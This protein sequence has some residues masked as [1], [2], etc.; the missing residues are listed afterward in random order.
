MHEKH[1]Q[2]IVIPTTITIIIIV[3]VVVVIEDA[4]KGSEHLKKLNFR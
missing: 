4:F 1:T 3:V 2:I